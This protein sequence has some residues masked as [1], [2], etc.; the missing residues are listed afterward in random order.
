MPHIR[1][2]YQE[3]GRPELNQFYKVDY[4]K[5]YEAVEGHMEDPADTYSQIKLPRRATR[6][7][8]GYD[9][10]SPFTF[11]LEPGETIKIE[12]GVG[13]V[14]DDDKFLLCVPRS[15][16]GFKYRIKLDNTCGI[17]DADYSGAANGGHI[18]AKLTNCGRKLVH[19]GRGEAFMQG[20]I[21][22]YFKTDDDD[23]DGERT[24][25]FGSTG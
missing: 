9:F 7:S 10:Y 20:I 25:G 18:M 4:D 21:L 6:L 17:I 5:Y 13:I 8:A 1:S 11:E 12:T 22:P 19:V 15:G 16:L 2:Q 24:G 3:K 14:L 23:A